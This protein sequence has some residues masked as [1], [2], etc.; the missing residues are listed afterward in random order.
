MKSKMIESVKLS[1]LYS[2]AVGPIIIGG[3]I[4]LY[5]MDRIPWY[6]GE[7]A[8][9]FDYVWLNVGILG[10]FLLTTFLMKWR[11]KKRGK[12]PP[13]D[14]RTL[15][16]MKNYLL[17]LLS[18]IFFVSAIILLIL[19]FLGIETIEIGWIFVYVSGWIIISLGGALIASRA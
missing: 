3:N 2:L 19:F 14:E 1:A 18:I 6:D 5:F 7:S 13:V 4:F 10:T 11:E 15:K 9:F 16:I 8:V 12:V 17:W